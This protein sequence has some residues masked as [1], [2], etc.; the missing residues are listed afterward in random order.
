MSGW[1]AAL[2]VA[3]PEAA[4][5]LMM[6]WIE[7]AADLVVAWQKRNGWPENGGQQNSA[8]GLRE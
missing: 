7:G 8:L 5:G 2:V 1:A 3:W 6:A 4:F